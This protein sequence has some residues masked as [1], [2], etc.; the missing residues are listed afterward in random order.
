MFINFKSKKRMYLYMYYFFGIEI[1]VSLFHYSFHI[2]HIRMKVFVKLL[3]WNKVGPLPNFRSTYIGQ[4]MSRRDQTQRSQ[5]EE[6]FSLTPCSFRQSVFLAN[7]ELISKNS[8]QQKTVGNHIV[9]RWTQ[10]KNSAT[11]ELNTMSYCGYYCL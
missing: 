6:S 9:P 5:I 1:N 8:N 10:K 2:L 11:R 3:F 7:C 4:P